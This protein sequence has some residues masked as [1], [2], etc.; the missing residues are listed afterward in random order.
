MECEAPLEGRLAAKTQKFDFDVQGGIKSDIW[1]HLKFK[2]HSTSPPPPECPQSFG[3]RYRSKVT[4]RLWLRAQSVGRF[5]PPPPTPAHLKS[6]PIVPSCPPSRLL[7][8]SD[9]PGAVYFSG[10]RLRR[11]RSRAP[12]SCQ[13]EHL[14]TPVEPA[15][16]IGSFLSIQ[17]SS[18]Y[19]RRRRMG[20]DQPRLAFTSSPRLS[21]PPS[22]R[23]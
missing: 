16:K 20:I 15:R 7:L 3:Q 19:I 23:C 18:I 6:F 14:L 2:C 12:L 8:C 9:K 10:C 21:R 17:A 5:C 4:S 1:S 22:G 13:S 11:R